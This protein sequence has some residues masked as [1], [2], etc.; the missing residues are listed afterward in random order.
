MQAGSLICFNLVQKSLA[1][2]RILLEVSVEKMSLCLAWLG[3]IL[4][5][6]KVTGTSSLGSWIASAKLDT[7]STANIPRL[8]SE[9]MGSDCRAVETHTN[10]CMHAG[11]LA[12]GPT[13]QGPLP[14]VWLLTPF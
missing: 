3:Q 5:L 1:F 10:I 9:T 7:L 4:L 11:T 13:S 2:A 6:R 12:L 8:P 14:R